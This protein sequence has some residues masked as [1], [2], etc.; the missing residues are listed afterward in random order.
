MI[1]GQDV[2]PAPEEDDYLERVQREATLRL[3]AGTAA[4]N[5]MHRA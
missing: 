2:P 1:V 3:K 5:I 4:P